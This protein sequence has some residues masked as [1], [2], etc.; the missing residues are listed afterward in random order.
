MLKKGKIGFYLFSSPKRRP[1][2]ISQIKMFNP[3][4]YIWDIKWDTRA[5][6][7]QMSQWVNEYT[8]GRCISF[9][10][11]WSLKTSDTTWMLKKS[12]MPHQVICLL[13]HK[14]YDKFKETKVHVVWFYIFFYK[15]VLNFLIWE[16]YP[17]FLETVFRFFY[18]F[19]YVVLGNPESSCTSIWMN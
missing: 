7:K 11:I 19:F 4:Y 12:F 16:I 8:E 3:T 9:H 10:F 15:L 13:S 14:L 2:E 5:L 18:F 6:C 1:G 17:C